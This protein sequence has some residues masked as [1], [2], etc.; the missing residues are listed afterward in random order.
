M[1]KGLLYFYTKYPTDIVIYGLNSYISRNPLTKQLTNL[2]QKEAETASPSQRLK[3]M[4][5][6]NVNDTIDTRTRPNIDS[7][8]NIDFVAR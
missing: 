3:S 7:I 6:V 4:H 5:N 1:V 8:R 2:Y